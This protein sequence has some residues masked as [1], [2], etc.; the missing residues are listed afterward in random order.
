M[1]LLFKRWREIYEGECNTEVEWLFPGGEEYFKN[2]LND[3]ASLRKALYESTLRIAT[4]TPEYNCRLPFPGYL[5]DKVMII[6]GRTASFDNVTRRLN[7]TTLPRIHF[8][9]WG[10]I[11]SF[12]RAMPP[13]RDLLQQ[14]R[15][16]I[17][18][19]GLLDSGLAALSRFRKFLGRSEKPNG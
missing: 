14:L 3:Q 1:G 18:H 8:M 16:S 2:T 17:H 4:L 9:H 5:Q 15:W 10:S 6:H 12:D 11:K 13:G 19:R 7:R